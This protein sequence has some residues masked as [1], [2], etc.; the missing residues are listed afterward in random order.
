MISSKNRSSLLVLLFVLSGIYFFVFGESGFLERM[1]LADE[2]KRMSNSLGSLEAENSELRDEYDDVMSKDGDKSYQEAVKSGFI[3]KGKK[4]LFFK[5]GD[6]E[7][8]I[9]SV[10]SP[11]ET[12]YSVEAAHLRILWIV[13]SIMILLFYFGRRSR[14]KE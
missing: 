9:S 5:G 2:Q 10:R 6:D 14:I 12:D 3:S 4:Y 13:A 7:K 1:H 8:E 11:D